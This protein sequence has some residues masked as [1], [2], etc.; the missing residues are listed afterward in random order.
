MAILEGYLTVTEAAKEL[1]LT[2]WGVRTAIQEG[3]LAA[4]P[5]AETSRTKLISRAEV[6]RYKR[7]HKGRRGKRPQPDNLTEQQ[8]K[9]R[10]YQAAYYQRRKA[11]RQQQPAA[12]PAE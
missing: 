4:V 11:A 8:R 5:L 10:A 2:L 3:R 7:E 12:E 1:G 6:E 9:Q